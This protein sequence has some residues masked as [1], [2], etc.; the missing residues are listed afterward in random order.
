MNEELELVRSCADGDEAAWEEF[1]RRYGAFL[2][3]MIRRALAGARGRLPD[4]DEVA[5]VK[6]E[7]L[8]WLVGDEGRV[9]RTY[10]GESKITSWLGVLVGRRARRIAARGAGLAMKT[11]SFDAL[12]PEASSHLAMTRGG[13]GEAEARSSALEALGAAIEELPER[14]RVLIRGAFFDQRSYV[15][16]AQELGVRA[17]SVGQLLFRAK[18]RL[19]ERLGGDAFLERLS[20]IGLSLLIFLARG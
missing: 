6:N 16:L 12:G 8:A 20:G 15:D 5:D 14:D 1:L 13:E 9:L 7:V 10:R 18:K 3:F 4:P 17:D 19:K 2:E 11:V